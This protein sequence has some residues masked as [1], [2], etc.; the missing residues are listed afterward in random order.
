MAMAYSLFFGLVANISFNIIMPVDD[1]TKLR[2]NIIAQ[3][4]SAFICHIG[5]MALA[6][7]LCL[8]A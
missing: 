2:I 1:S 8:P 3:L 5:F 7:Y 4:G 6:S